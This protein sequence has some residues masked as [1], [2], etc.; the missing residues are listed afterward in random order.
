MRRL[1]ILM[2]LLLALP[3]MA[4]A[5]LVG[6]KSANTLWALDLD[7]GEK[8]AE[9]TTGTGPHEVS[10]SSDGKLAVVANYGAATPNNTLTVVD[11]LHKRVLRT[12]D[13]GE[14]ARPH[15]LRFLPDN[16]R[17]VVTTEDSE[18][19]L[20]VELNQ[21]RV[22]REIAIGPGKG[23][24]VAL[25]PDTH[26]AYVAH[27][28]GG[29]ISVIDLADAKKTGEVA[30]GEGAEGIAVTPDGREV[31]VGNRQDDTISVI[32]TATLKVTHTLASK[33]FPIR[34]A[35]TPD[36]RHALVT[37]ARSAEL[38]VFDIAG[39]REVARV[40][41]AQPGAEYRDTLLGRAALPIGAAVRPD[42]SRVY[43]AISGAD[44]I[45]VID[46]ATW[47]VIA[48][49]KTGREPDALAVIVDS[50]R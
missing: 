50:D 18:R 33:A 5:L 2:T 26:R 11:W 3:A 44:E 37:N 35:I 15:G 38:A 4:D 20:V 8:L 14:N 1:W 42:G 17:V 47:K 49:W 16:H 21:G 24:M 41:L 12:I 10:V 7:S 30:T 32:D 31:W 6:N 45:A 43:V 28:E 46:T 27:I 29:K 40:A 25:S 9:F 39:K 34:V 36:G 22:E 48:R 23:H 13:L 19:L